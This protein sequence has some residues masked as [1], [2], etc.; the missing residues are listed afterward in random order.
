MYQPQNKD[1]TN[2][3]PS[4]RVQQLTQENQSKDEQLRSLSQLLEQKDATIAA[5]QQ[6]LQSLQLQPAI[7]QGGT[8]QPFQAARAAQQAGLVWETLP[9]A[10]EDMRAAFAAVVHDKAYFRTNREKGNP[11]IYEFDLQRKCWKAMPKHPVPDGYAI[12]CIDDTLT[13]VGGYF[14]KI[15]GVKYSNK[16]YSFV[17]NSWV[18]QLPSMPTK[19]SAVSVAYGD[20]MLVVSGGYKDLLLLTVEVLNVRSRQWSSASSLPY[21]LS[22]YA[23]S[24]AICG[25]YVYMATCLV[26]TEMGKNI[27]YRCSLSALAQSKPKTKLWQNIDDQSTSYSTMV[28]VDDQ[29]IAVGGR[30]ARY[31]PS[32]EVLRYNSSRNVW[33][34][35]GHMTVPRSDCLVA[36]LPGKKLMVVGAHEAAHRRKATVAAL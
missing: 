18:E 30:D 24:T 27:L 32:R 22:K 28:V 6:Q 2:Y 15:F 26:F 12:V 14:E 17:S 9:D 16:L 10:P 13:T 5:L 29:L 1:S 35:V 33:E 31:A 8:Q 23:G 4:D 25:G 11:Q 19:R 20:N 7:A 21:G 3:E 36:V 34:V